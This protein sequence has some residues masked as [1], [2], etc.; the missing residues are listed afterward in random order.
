MI[1]NLIINQD[2]EQLLPDSLNKFKLKY[3]IKFEECPER[4][5]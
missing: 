2:Y 1:E 4:M 3:K 5:I